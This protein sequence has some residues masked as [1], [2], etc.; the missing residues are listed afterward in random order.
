MAHRPAVAVKAPP[1]KAGIAQRP[2]GAPPTG[3]FINETQALAL[4]AR[5]ADKWILVDEAAASSAVA[6]RPQT[7]YG[8]SSFTN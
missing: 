5:S 4:P 2:P 6:E 8:L 1:P 3:T 7:V